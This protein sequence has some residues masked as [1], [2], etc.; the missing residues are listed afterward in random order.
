MNGIIFWMELAILWPSVSSLQTTRIF[1][2]F[3]QLIALIRV[4]HNGLCFFSWF[5]F[6]FHFH[7]A[8]KKKSEGWSSVSFLW[9]YIPLFQVT[10]YYW[11]YIKYLILS[12]MLFLLHQSVFVKLLHRFNEGKFFSGVIL[13]NELVIQ[14]YISLW[15]LFLVILVAD[16][17]LWCIG[18]SYQKQNELSQSL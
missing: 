16:T 9:P 12:W 8:K 4:R 13:S 6:L 2:S 14:M 1:F 11:S 7:P 5:D 15:S 17:I 18:L 10:V 3:K